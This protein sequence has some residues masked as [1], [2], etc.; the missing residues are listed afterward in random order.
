MCQEVEDGLGALEAAID[1]LYGLDPASVSDDALHE[2]VV[3]LE[4]QTCRFAGAGPGSWGT[5]TGG[6]SGSTTAPAP[7]QGVWGVS[8]TCR[9]APPGGSSGG[10][11]SS[12]PCPA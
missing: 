6:A 12:P 2:L 10:R 1:A 4:R 8:A 9:Q 11:A 3:G 7:R 5:G